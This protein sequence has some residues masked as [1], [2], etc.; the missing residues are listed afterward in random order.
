MPSV[1]RAA[2][3][4]QQLCAW[5]FFQ[6]MLWERR[7]K[8]R[9]DAAS[10]Y[11][12]FDDAVAGGAGGESEWLRAATA[13]QTP[14]VSEASTEPSPV[15]NSVRQKYRAKL[16]SLFRFQA[17]VEPL[18]NRIS[19]LSRISLSLSDRDFGV[20]VRSCLSSRKG[21]VCEPPGKS[22][23]APGTESSSVSPVFGKTR[24]LG[25]SSF[26]DAGV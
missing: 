7:A 12:K 4:L 6:H 13:R 24:A 2:V 1:S 22:Q 26:Y 11:A 9:R 25:F 17:K 14:R 3:A 15:P 8:R 5:V 19:N 21:A 20:S 10:A 16:P 18:S 23:R